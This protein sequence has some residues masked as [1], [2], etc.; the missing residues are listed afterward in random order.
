MLC[1]NVRVTG[2][3]PRSDDR[4]DKNSCLSPLDVHSWAKRGNRTVKQISQ[5]HNTR[6]LVPRPFKVKR[7]CIYFSSV[8][9]YDL[10]TRLFYPLWTALTGTENFGR[11]LR[12][13]SVSLVKDNNQKTHHSAYLSEK[14]PT[15]TETKWRTVRSCSHCFG[16]RTGSSSPYVT[17]CT[18]SLKRYL[19]F[20]N[21]SSSGQGS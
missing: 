9:W 16:I 18:A 19:I 8:T 2:I 20:N 11:P 3:I 21:F 17:S 7:L 5:P 14:K 10:G 12:R 1:K 15:Q 4:A 13:T 6:F